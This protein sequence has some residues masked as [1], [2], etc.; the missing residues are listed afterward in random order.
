MKKKPEK[1]DQGNGIRPDSQ[2]LVLTRRAAIK[3]IAV[4]LGCTV[5]GVAILRPTPSS[6]WSYSSYF[7]TGY[8]SYFSSYT[9]YYSFYSSYTS[10]IR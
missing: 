3:R 1:M 10:F 4:T 5:A 6:G 7:S 9:S 8:S 2:E